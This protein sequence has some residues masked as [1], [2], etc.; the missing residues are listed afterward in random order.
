M[1]E[2]SFSHSLLRLGCFC[3]TFRLSRRQMPSTFFRFIHEPADC[4]NAVSRRK[5]PAFAGAGSTAILARQGND[6][7]GQ[8]LFVIRPA[9]YFALRRSVLSQNASD[10]AFR[11]RQFL[12]DIIDT[13]PSLRRA[14]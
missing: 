1:D 3:G 12:A 9:R 10:A 2:P 8:R 7:L 5:P 13:A 11:D 6:I 4:S 14:Q